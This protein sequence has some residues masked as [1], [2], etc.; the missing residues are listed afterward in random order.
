MKTFILLLITL[1]LAAGL[2][3]AASQDPVRSI[4]LPLVQTEIKTGE[5]REKVVSFCSIC[6]SV[7]Y[8]TTQPKFQRAQW[9]GTVNKM[10]K[11]FGAPI[12]EDDAKKIINY[13]TTNYGT[14]D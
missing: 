4:Q 1:A 8:I 13:L 11:V 5:D 7:D 12:S 2:T 14:G 3:S 9:T 10:I 6:H